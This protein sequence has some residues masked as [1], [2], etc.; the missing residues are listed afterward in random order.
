MKRSRDVIIIGG[1]VI[2]SASA[3]FLASAPAFGG[4]VLVVERDPTYQTGSTARS[5]GGIRQQFSTPENILMSQFAEA[6]MSTVGD[7]LALGDE[8]ADVPFTRN[9]YLILASAD[10]AATLEANVAIQH[11][12][13]AGTRLMNTTE[14]SGRFPWLNT[15]GLAMGSFGESRE[16]W[17][18][19]YALLQAFRRKARALGVEYVDGDATGLERTGNRITGVTFA[20]GERL[21]S[22]WVVNAAGVHAQTVA[23]SCGVDIP[24]RPRKRMIFVIDCQD[25]PAACPL[26]F[27]PDGTYVRPEGR[28]FICGKS[29]DA[30][31]DPDCLDF[32]VD[33][34]FFNDV[35]WP[36]LAHRIPA[37]EAVRVVN[38]WA[39][40]Y[41]YNTLDQNAI[42]GRH[43]E[44][45]NLVFANGFS[46]HGLQQSPAV[47]RAVSEIITMGGFATI[48]LSRFGFERVLTQTPLAEHNVF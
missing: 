42:I 20:S 44:V 7:T 13:G 29:P 4:S 10:G 25:P 27:D 26:T 46:G 1:G 37:F 8:K 6:F 15:D 32:D 3:Y 19:P 18:D 14:L 35:I 21:C 12:Y 31:N 23:A 41:A 40:H 47:G 2:G 38:A 33:H 22:D 39:G 34:D 48:D 45:D 16:G 17:T 5:V 30:D 9:G 11:E 28:F 24:V 36:S 43:P